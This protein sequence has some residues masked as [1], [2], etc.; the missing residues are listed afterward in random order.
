MRRA[1]SDCVECFHCATP[2]G[3]TTRC[4][5]VLYSYCAHACQVFVQIMYSVDMCKPGAVRIGELSRRT[6]VAVELLRAWERRYGSSAPSARRAGSAST[7][8][9]TSGGCALM[10]RHLAAAGG[11]RGGSRGG[12]GRARRRRRSTRPRAARHRAATASRAPLDA[13]D[14]TARARRLDSLLAT[15]RSRP[16]CPRQCSPTSPRSASAGSAARRRSRRSTSPATCCAAACS[17]LARNWDRGSRPARA[18]RLRARGSTRSAAHR[19]RPR[20]RRARLAHQLPRAG[21]AGRVDWRTQVSCCSRTPSSLTAT[22]S[23][24]PR[25][26]RRASCGASRA[27]RASTSPAAASTGR[28]AARRRDAAHGRPGCSGR[29]AAATEE[30]GASAGAR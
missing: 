29:R 5:Q 30:P 17:E 24:T 14:E 20:A 19:L 22:P 4:V 13:L 16:S 23:G 10:Q 6:G 7:R 18:A 25:P 26:G 2:F 11:G 12:R 1:D 9:R 8:P 28:R 27:R 3:W 21:H 15:S